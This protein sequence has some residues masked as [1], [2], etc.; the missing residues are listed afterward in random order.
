MNWAVNAEEQEHSNMADKAQEST[1]LE[2]NWSLYTSS[3]HIKENHSI[4]HEKKS[5][6][7]TFRRRQ[8]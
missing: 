7:D 2:N 4:Y 8:L 1:N 6:K 3:L 5:C